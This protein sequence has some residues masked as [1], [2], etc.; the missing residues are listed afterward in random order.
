MVD[1]VVYYRVSNPTMAINNVEDLYVYL[2][3]TL[4]V[5]CV[6]FVYPLNCR[7]TLWVDAVQGAAGIHSH[8]TLYFLSNQNYTKNQFKCMKFLG[9]VY[10]YI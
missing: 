4:T 6:V 3:D 9:D 7:G 5:W 8:F 10:L 2:L 1:A